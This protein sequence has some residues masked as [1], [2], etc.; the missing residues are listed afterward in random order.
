M[1]GAIFIFKSTT[2]AERARRALVK[3]GIS[4]DMVRPDIKFTNQSC[5][6]GVRVS[7]G[8]LPEAVEVLKANRIAAM[9][10]VVEERNGETREMR[11]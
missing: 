9:K 5:N 3:N 7:E 6:Y 10:I 11:F 4:A 2:F 8:Y 1:S